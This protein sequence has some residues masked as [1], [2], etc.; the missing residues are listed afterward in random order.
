MERNTTV[1]VQRLKSVVVESN[2][3]L[4]DELGADV[5]PDLGGNLR[6]YGNRQNQKLKK[7]KKTKRRRRQNMPSES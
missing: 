2:K 1:H 3:G 7:K 6:F 4:V 5:Y